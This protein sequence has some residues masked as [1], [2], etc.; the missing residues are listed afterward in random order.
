[1]NLDVTNKVSVIVPVYR[2]E[3]SIQ[4]CIESLLTQTYKN[5]EVILVDDG[6]PDNSG[7][8]CDQY[9]NDGRVKVIHEKNKGVSH[10]RNIGL[11]NATGTYITFCDA[12]DYYSPDHIEKS[13]QAA[14]ANKSDITISGY[15]IEIDKGKFISSVNESSRMVSSDEVIEHCTIDNEFG[16][17]CWNKLYRS[18][19]VKGIKFP[20]DMAMLE[21]TYFLFSALK[22]AKNMYY[23]ASPLYYYCNN[24]ESAVRN[25]DNLFSEKNTLKYNDS[26]KK[27]VAKFN[28]EDNNLL[29]ATIF[30]FAL[31]YKIKYLEN[32][33]FKN[34]FLIKNLNKDLKHYALGAYR[35]RD[36]SLKRKIKWTIELIIL[37]DI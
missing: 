21:D 32:N 4:R 14:I 12:D 34:K 20:E 3:R 36:I 23:L 5:I 22:R 16:G 33:K 13:L 8:I 30:E 18:D 9:T 27:I 37:K 28:L 31:I 19:L 25:V 24:R 2:A 1:M 6:S 35:C 29:Y 11:D 10:A 15:Y 7:K 26:W 17:F